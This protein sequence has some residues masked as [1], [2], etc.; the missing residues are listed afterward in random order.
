MLKKSLIKIL[1]ISLSLISAISLSTLS[2][3]AA[4]IDDSISVSSEITPENTV[5]DDTTLPSKY[6]SKDL[7]YVT[8]MKQQLYNDCWAYASL[9]AFE[10]K[11]LREGINIESMSVNHLNAWAT[12]LSNGKGWQRDYTGDGYAEIALGYLTSWQGGIEESVTGAIDLTSITAGDLVDTSQAKYGTTAVE[13]LSDTDPDN[14]KRAIMEHGGVY[15]AY[16]HAP[17]CLSTDKLS[18]YMPETYNGG[19]TGHAV[20]I[21][22]WNNN[23]AIRNFNGAINKTPVNKGA[24]LVKNSWGENNTEGGYFWISY[25]DKYV[26]SDKYRPSYAIKSVQEINENTKLVQN[27]IFGSTYEFEY[28]DREE[29]TYINH[30]DFSSEYNTLDKVVFETRSMGADYSIYYIPSEDEKPVDDKTQWVKLF[31]NTVT[32]EGYHCADIE[33]FKLP[34][35]NGS[36]AIEINTASTNNSLKP[37]DTDYVRNSLGVGEWLRKSNGYYTFLND[38]KYGDSFIYYDNTMT[39]L[40][41]WYKDYNNDEIGGTFVIKAVTTKSKPEVTNLGDVNLDGAVNIQDATLIQKY[42]VGLTDLA[43]TALLNADYNQNGKV[44]V[45]DATQIQKSLAG[46][47]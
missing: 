41:Q 18:Y 35:G 28:V 20:E 27:E 33:D 17:S 2:A 21:V 3:G 6:S 5:T 43:D 29:V 32:Y 44:E 23:Y 38:S 31:E 11:L 7:G 45:T 4:V 24:W 39:D 30:F 25:E 46:I 37:T 22:G 14:I 36:I 10:S 9:G 1:T 42:I 19:Y 34:T 13:Y 15:S 8:E 26:F 47:A 40:M 16:A 12:T